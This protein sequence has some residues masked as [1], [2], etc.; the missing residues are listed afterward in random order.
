MF[1]NLDLSALS[2]LRSA[3]SEGSSAS[4]VTTTQYV[5]TQPPSQSYLLRLQ[6]LFRPVRIGN[7]G[8]PNDADV[9]LETAKNGGL[10]VAAEDSTGTETVP[11]HGL[12]S[13][14]TPLHSTPL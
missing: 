9:A 13:R 12:S 2:N 7:A 11:G 10:N 14:S 3:D 6:G 8:T 4:V 5:R 1:P